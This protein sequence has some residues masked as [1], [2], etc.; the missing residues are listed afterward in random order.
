MTAQEQFIEI[1]RLLHNGT[2]A[3]LGKAWKER[4]KIYPTTVKVKTPVNY[5][6][7]NA[8]LLKKLGDL[9]LNLKSPI[10]YQSWEIGT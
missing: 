8:P 2:P 7:L 9:E 5:D 4:A 1:K 10:Y 3:E 6:I